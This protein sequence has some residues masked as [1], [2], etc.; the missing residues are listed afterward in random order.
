MEVRELESPL[1][2]KAKGVSPVQPPVL[3][4]QDAIHDGLWVEL[5]FKGK[6]TS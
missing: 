3:L 4:L 6:R 2:S 5:L 1:I